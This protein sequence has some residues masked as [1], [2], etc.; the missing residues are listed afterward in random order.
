MKRSLCGLLVALAFSG[1]SQEA[2][3]KIEPLQRPPGAPPAPAS[4]GEAP[5]PAAAAPAVPKDAVLLRWKLVQGTPVA[6]RLTLALDRAA[7]AFES[8]PAEPKADK[9]KKGGKDEEA[10][11]AT[12]APAAVPSEY[13]YVLE[14]DRAGERHLRVTPSG[15]AAPEDAT[16]SDRGFIIDGLPGRERNLAT[17]VLE[18]PRDPVSPGESWSLATAL[19]TPDALGTQFRRATGGAERRNRV[20][21]VS[22]TPA[23]N[24]EQVATLEY[25]LLE[26]F[27]GLLTPARIPMAKRGS[28]PSAPQGPANDEDAAGPTEGTELG[29]TVKITGRGEFLVKAGQ[30]RS[31]EGTLA[32]SMK[33]PAQSAMGLPVGTYQARLAPVSAPQAPATP[34]PAAPTATPPAP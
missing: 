7:P 3:G 18:L 22:V 28:R 21:L 10:P 24:G 14:L 15:G 34:A 25:D 32:T 29:A 17:L 2:P 26:Q 31:W 20:K 19:L 1:C 8:A 33:G 4:N 6:F 27:G 30:W 23:D 16:V 12:A 5:A 9:K 13:T 11:A